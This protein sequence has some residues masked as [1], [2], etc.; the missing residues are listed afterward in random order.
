MLFNKTIQYTN[1]QQKYLDQV[2][3]KTKQNNSRAT[4]QQR[5]WHLT[6]KI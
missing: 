4:K 1:F 3:D 6:N 2:L 5:G